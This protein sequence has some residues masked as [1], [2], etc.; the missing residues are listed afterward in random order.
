MIYTVIFRYGNE[1]YDYVSFPKYTF[2]D[3]LFKTVPELQRIVKK[4]ENEQTNG[5]N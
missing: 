1:G 4:Y 5:S 2:S 3:H